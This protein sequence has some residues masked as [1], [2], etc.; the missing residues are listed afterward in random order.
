MSDEDPPSER[1]RHKSHK[2]KHGHRKYSEKEQ[3]I[4]NLGI[5][6]ISTPEDDQP[7]S[8]PAE[9]KINAG[10]IRTVGGVKYECIEPVSYRFTQ[11]SQQFVF[12]MKKQNSKKV[13]HRIIAIYHKGDV[14]LASMGDPT[15][16]MPKGKPKD[17]TIGSFVKLLKEAQTAHP[18]TTISINVS[19]APPGSVVQT[20]RKRNLSP[21]IEANAMSGSGSCESDDDTSYA[22]SVSSGHE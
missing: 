3:V 6:V 20:K 9:F 10:E 11:K 12:D 21:V 15:K 1:H 2:R 16:D 7:Y 8:D 5:S 22:P 4:S 14:I 13:I 17:I 19:L 18:G